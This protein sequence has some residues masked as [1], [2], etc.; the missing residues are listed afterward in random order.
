MFGTPY[1]GTKQ[2]KAF[3][4]TPRKSTMNTMVSKRLAAAECMLLGYAPRNMLSTIGKAA[5]GV[6]HAA[7]TS[8]SRLKSPPQLIRAFRSRKL[9]ITTLMELNAMAALAKT[10]FSMRPVKGY[11]APAAIGTPST[12]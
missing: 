8:P 2:A 5:W 9:F 1:K 12:L 6:S 10:G 11:N 3:V 4:L 7:T